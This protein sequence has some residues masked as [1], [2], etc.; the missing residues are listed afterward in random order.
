MEK[1]LFNENSV[2]LD[3]Y[4]NLRKTDMTKA[5]SF[6]R[7]ILL[8]QGTGIYVDEWRYEK[9]GKVKKFVLYTIKYKF[10]VLG[11][12]RKTETTTR[13]LIFNFE[14]NKFYCKSYGN[15]GKSE[16]SF[17]RMIRHDFY[18]RI[19]TEI[20]SKIPELKRPIKLYDSFANRNHI[21]LD[22]LYDLNPTNG[23]E[24][25]N[26]VYS[27]YDNPFLDFFS[28]GHDNNAVS[29][30]KC[31]SKLRNLRS[32]TF[33]KLKQYKV[34]ISDALSMGIKEID[35]S[36]TDTELRDTLN[37]YI[38]KSIDCGDVEL[39][40]DKKLL[41]TVKKVNGITILK[42]ATPT[43]LDSIR[44]NLATKAVY[45]R[46]ENRL[47]SVHTQHG[48]LRVAPETSTIPK[49]LLRLFRDSLTGIKISDGESDFKLPF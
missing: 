2:I 4:L 7:R 1:V 21:P 46:Y 6:L 27:G 47:Y 49:S 10:D 30:G 29:I 35:L 23:R 36:L 48:E 34:L 16:R 37:E 5:K 20:I 38:S 44:R 24:V 41:S 26:I 25:K 12:M 3:T 18:D 39:V 14:T 45:F 33:E 19:E 43:E 31:Y 15:G 40:Y 17:R 11:R 8:K 42:T 22:V 13:A 32:D 28:S 9:V